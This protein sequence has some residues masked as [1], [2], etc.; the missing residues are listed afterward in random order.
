MIATVEA[1]IHGSAASPYWTTIPLYIAYSLALLAT[2]SGLCSFTQLQFPITALD[3]H[4]RRRR[5]IRHARAVEEAQPIPTAPAPRIERS[6]L[7]EKVPARGLPRSRKHAHLTPSPKQHGP[8]VTLAASRLHKAAEVI[9]R[10]VEQHAAGL[11]VQGG[12]RTL[13]LARL[14][15]LQTALGV[16]GD[17]EL[18]AWP[19]KG[20]VVMVRT[21]R[22]RALN[23]MIEL[24]STLRRGENG[25]TELRQLVVSLAQIRDLIV[26]HVTIQGEEGRSRRN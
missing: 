12:G 20:F 1:T 7:N 13:L 15:D 8:L 26:E 18:K 16:L 23:Q 2:V 5:A 3:D 19:D 25:D 22:D 24:R 11:H 14:A 21:P 10:F 9:D 4:M 17:A 6:G